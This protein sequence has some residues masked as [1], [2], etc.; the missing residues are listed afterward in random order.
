MEN[1]VA[2]VKVRKCKDCGEELS[3]FN[4]DAI[5]KHYLATGHTRYTFELAGAPEWKGYWGRVAESDS[6]G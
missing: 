6:N 5:E 3:P 1:S 2:E 4:I